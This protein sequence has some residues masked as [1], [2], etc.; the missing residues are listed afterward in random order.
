MRGSAPEPKPRVLLDRVRG[1]LAM[2]SLGVMGGG[3]AGQTSDRD[4]AVGGGNDGVGHLVS[5]NSFHLARW[6]L[7]DPPAPRQTAS[8]SPSTSASANACKRGNLRAA[9]RLHE[10]KMVDVVRK[11]LNK[12]S[13]QGRD[14]RSRSICRKTIWRSSVGPC[15][16]RSTGQIGL[17]TERG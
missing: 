8:H 16:N 7:H 11:V 13:D 10:E 17:L 12:M 6:V 15:R 4:F 2:V 1:A 9:A 5:A 3:A 14:W